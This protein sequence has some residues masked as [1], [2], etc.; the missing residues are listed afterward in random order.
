MPGSNQSPPLVVEPSVTN[1]SRRLEWIVWGALIATVLA[2]AAAFIVKRVQQAAPPP[3]PII[4]PVGEFT[5][6]NQH[7]Q[8]VTAADLRGQVWIANI[9]FTRCA[10]PCPVMTQAMADF[11][12]SLPVRLVTLTTDPDNDTPEVLKRFGEK[13]GADFRRWSFLTGGKEQI[14]R[15]AVQGLKLVALEKPEAERS[16][17]A[18]LFIH[19]TL[20]VVVDR[21]GNLRAAYELEDPHLKSKVTKAVRSLL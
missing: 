5:L 15:L 9:V 17:A 10:G 1:S 21:Q 7:G 4:G 20:F 12:K 14:A 13:Y 11:Q 18:D 6:T 2:I 19:S 16:S 3:L 8:T